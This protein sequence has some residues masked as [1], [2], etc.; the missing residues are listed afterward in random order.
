MLTA[1]PIPKRSRSR[2]RVTL[3]RG[4]LDPAT[5]QSVRIAPPLAGRAIA[6]LDR[7]RRRAR[8]RRPGRPRR[9]RHFRPRPAWSMSAARRRSAATA[10]RRRHRD[11]DEQIADAFAID[12]GLSSARRPLPHGDCTRGGA[13]LPRRAERR[14]RAP[15]GPRAFRGDDQD[16]RRLRARACRRRR[17]QA[18]PSAGQRA[19]RRDRLRRL[20][21]ARDA[22]GRRRRGRP[23]TPTC[24]CTTWART[25]TTAS[26]SRASP[27]RNGAPRR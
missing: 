14:E 8:A 15:S 10:G 7:P 9:R 20:P 6:R 1:P 5:R 25:S 16:R 24:S 13:R 12:L 18:T 27:R 26:A 21:R 11:L 23:P 2:S 22:G 4:P 3:D 17:G 19:L